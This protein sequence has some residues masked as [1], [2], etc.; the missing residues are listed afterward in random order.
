MVGCPGDTL[1]HEINAPET[2]SRSW[3]TVRRIL[4]PLVRLYWRIRLKIP[5]RDEYIIPASNPLHSYRCY[6]GQTDP[7][8]PVSSGVTESL[9]ET[10]LQK[11]GFV[12]IDGQVFDLREDGVYRFYRLPSISEQRMVCTGGSASLLKMLSYLWVYG[13]QD[14]N[15]S[16]DRIFKVLSKRSV[17]CACTALSAQSQKIMAMLGIEAR[18]ISGMS[19]E[20]W[21]GQDDGHT[22]L[23]LYHNGQWVMYDPSLGCL[24]SHE[25]QPLSLRAFKN[26]DIDQIDLI[27]PA[28]QVRRGSFYNKKY[29]YDFWVDER[30]LSETSLR[31]WYKHVLEVPMIEKEGNFY[32]S[33]TF[34]APENISR[35]N[36]RYKPLSDAEFIRLF[37]G[38]DHAA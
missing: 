37:Y 12:E 35:M 20:V 30:V 5:V 38:D 34:V 10:L 1:M 36:G 15:L 17:S 3:P 23:E 33:D 7:I 13:N 8:Y 28:I 19:N 24:F 18:I 9:S 4:R 2:F 6:A 26:K 25:G 14:K 32:Y 29:N 27:Y 11:P 31:Q 21:G 16:Q 22:L